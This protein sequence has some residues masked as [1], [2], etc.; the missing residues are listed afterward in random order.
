MIRP[1]SEQIEKLVRQSAAFSGRAIVT[2]DDYV[3]AAKN[4]F[5]ELNYEGVSA[6]PLSATKK[7]HI[8]KAKPRKCR[9]CHRDASRTTFKQEAHAVPEC[10]GNKTLISYDECDDCNDLF[11]RT[12]EHHLDLMTR[13]WRT[14]FGIKGKKKIP[15]YKVRSGTTR[16]DHNAHKHRIRISDPEN[17]IKFTDDA[18][19]KTRNVEIPCDPFIPVEV[20]RALTKIGLAILPS[21]FFGEY[22]PAFKWLREPLERTP[23]AVSRFAK[24]WMCYS[25]I[26]FQNPVAAV[27]RRRSSTDPLPAS[28]CMFSTFNLM[29]L[30]AIPLSVRDDHWRLAELRIP[31]VIVPLP[32]GIEPSWKALDLRSR[33]SSDDFKYTLHETYEE[34]FPIS[35][36]EFDAD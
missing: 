3:I 17:N 11:S 34:S 21:R 5:F 19:N 29:L 18:T 2:N 12:F 10:L 24:C 13:P 33:E 8:G 35:K 36:E 26:P 30:Y 31:R 20:F 6:Y 1:T 25:P 27:F 4:A 14:Y 22:G 28:V 32:A 23:A 7:Q 15:T 9:Y 16:I